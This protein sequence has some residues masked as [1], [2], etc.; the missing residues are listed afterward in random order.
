MAAAGSTAPTH[1]PGPART[2][3]QFPDQPRLAAAA[4]R[5][6]GR[7]R[8]SSSVAL[9]PWAM[10]RFN[11]RMHVPRAARCLRTTRRGGRSKRE[12]DGAGG[13]ATALKKAARGLQFARDAIAPLALFFNAG[14]SAPCL[15]V[16]GI[17][18]ACSLRQK[19]WAL[20]A[21]ASR[22]ARWYAGTASAGGSAGQRPACTCTWLPKTGTELSSNSGARRRS[23]LREESMRELQLRCGAQLCCR[24]RPDAQSHRRCC[25]MQRSAAFSI[26]FPPSQ[27]ALLA[28]TVA[29]KIVAH[30]RRS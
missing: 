28:Q 25:W 1:C 17:M 11:A 22:S 12:R 6:T 15:I 13:R 16:S 18:C 20:G 26:V 5:R 27:A 7:C 14:R 9:C 21:P 10:G 23:G 8:S 29:L 3:T 30:A 2:G 4:Q 24:C 19:P